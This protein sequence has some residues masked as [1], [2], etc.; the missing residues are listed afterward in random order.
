MG[1]HTHG[2]V[3]QVYI[4]LFSQWNF[5]FPILYPHYYPHQY[6]IITLFFAISTSIVL[7]PFYPIMSHSFALG[8]ERHICELVPPQA[9]QPGPKRNEMP[10][11]WSVTRRT[12]KRYH[13][14]RRKWLVCMY[15]CVCVCVCVYIYT[16]IYIHIHTRPAIFWDMPGTIQSSFKDPAWYAAVPTEICGVEGGS[17]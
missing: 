1:F 7:S 16:Y 8:Y 5:E 10:R 14:C 17:C 6:I 15:V 2:N 9:P 12:A 13:L 11:D 3:A 4:L